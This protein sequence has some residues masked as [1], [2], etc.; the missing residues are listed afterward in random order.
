M[1]FA[2]RNCDSTTTEMKPQPF[3]NGSIHLRETC[4]KCGSFVKWHKQE[5][6]SFRQRLYFVVRDLA[7]CESNEQF[8]L[9]KLQAAQL[10]EENKNRY[11]DTPR[12]LV[13]P[14]QRE[15]SDV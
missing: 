6:S 13:N 8:Q 14:L 4:T 5:S 15:F 3:K 7:F 1:L 12:D 2:C 10:V 11:L 9:L